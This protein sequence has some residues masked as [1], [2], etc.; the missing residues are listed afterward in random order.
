MEIHKHDS[1]CE[2][3]LNGYI[4]VAWYDKEHDE[5]RFHIY[6]QEKEGDK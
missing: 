5:T 3:I 1:Y 6:K 2:Y 4:M